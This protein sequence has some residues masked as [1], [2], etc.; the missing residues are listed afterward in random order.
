MLV[1]HSG[2]QEAGWLSAPGVDLCHLNWDCGAGCTRPHVF[3]SGDDN[4][5]HAK[6]SAC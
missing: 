6:L 3:C 4:R 5:C 2:A 1:P